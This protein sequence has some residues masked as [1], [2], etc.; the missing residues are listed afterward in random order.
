MSASLCG[1]GKHVET[2]GFALFVSVQLSA[3]LATLMAHVL[4][5]SL[6]GKAPLIS[7]MAFDVLLLTP[8]GDESSDEGVL[9]LEESMLL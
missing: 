5:S 6:F 3:L 9:A 7:V 2:V 8:F 1:P 4:T